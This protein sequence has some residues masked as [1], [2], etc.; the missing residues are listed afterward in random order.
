[1]SLTDLAVL[2]A[3]PGDLAAPLVQ[4]LEKENVKVLQESLLHTAPLR[5]NQVFYEAAAKVH[6]ASWAI[7]VSPMA[8]RFAFSLWQRFF[9]VWP[10]QI[11]VAAVGQSTALALHEQGVARVLYPKEESGAKAL[12]DLLGKENL[13]DQLIA[14]FR[15][16]TG[17]APFFYQLQE[18]GAIPFA[19]P[20]Y[21]RHVGD[22]EKA[23]LR[24]CQYQGRKVMICTSSELAR[25]VLPHQRLVIE[26]DVML[27]VSHPHIAA[28][29]AKENMAS[30]ICNNINPKT[31]L[32]K[33]KENR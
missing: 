8:V 6:E 21:E 12:F 28:V 7:F 26:N 19:V 3:R 5:E 15:A 17:Q 4:S 25:A 11:K 29:F 32:E 20:C 9:G 18:K 22:V 27:L 23:L 14:I 2:I 30:T 24:L 31:V 16:T 33:I 13:Q 1:M 10:V